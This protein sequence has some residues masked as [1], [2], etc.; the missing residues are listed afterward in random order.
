MGMFTEPCGPKFK[1]F[2]WSLLWNSNRAA[3]ICLSYLRVPDTS[4]ALVVLVPVRIRTSD[5]I[6]VV[7]LLVV[8]PPG[9]NRCVVEVGG[10]VGRSSEILADVVVFGRLVVPVL[11]LLSLTFT[12]IELGQ[13]CQLGVP[14]LLYQ[15]WNGIETGLLYSCYFC[16]RC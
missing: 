14:F 13:G 3:V 4:L 9:N 8:E 10:V 15:R 7:E 12:G 11:V 5:G 2:F 6:V 1:F 16:Q